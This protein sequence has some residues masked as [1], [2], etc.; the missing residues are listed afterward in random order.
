[1][2]KGILPLSFRD[3]LTA[4]SINTLL[5]SLELLVLPSRAQIGH[6][7]RAAK[8]TTVLSDTREQVVH[9]LF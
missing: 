2:V 7:A 3:L 9:V 1:M 4:R 8:G 5:A 6:L